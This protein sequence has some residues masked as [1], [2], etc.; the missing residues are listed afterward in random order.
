MV[1]LISHY[2]T[3]VLSLSLTVTFCDHRLS[4]H[5]DLVFFGG[6]PQI[7]AN[8]STNFKYQNSVKMTEIIQNP[9]NWSVPSFL[10]LPPL[11]PLP[12]TIPT[13]TRPRGEVW[14]TLRFCSVSRRRHGCFKSRTFRKAS[15]ARRDVEGGIWHSYIV[16]VIMWIIDNNIKT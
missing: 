9:W 16:M 8:T 4:F 12:P 5:P 7:R 13:P 2:P 6:T 1:L 3:T 14:K 15:A 10:H 11:T